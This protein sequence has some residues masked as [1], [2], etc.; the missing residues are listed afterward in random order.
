LD[1]QPYYEYPQLAPR[2]IFTNEPN[3]SRTV[4]Q[5]RN[6]WERMAYDTDARVSLPA[7]AKVPAPQPPA[8]H[9][10]AARTHNVWQAAADTMSQGATQ[11]YQQPQHTFDTVSDIAASELLGFSSSK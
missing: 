2:D 4:Q 10:R 8:W 5:R 9:N 6:A 11:T 1:I 7:S 3:W